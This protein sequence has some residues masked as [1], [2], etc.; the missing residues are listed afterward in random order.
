MAEKLIIIKTVLLTKSQ[1]YG[2]LFTQ[3]TKL[4]DSVMVS[5]VDHGFKPWLHQRKTKIGLVC[6]SRVWQIMGSSPGWV[7]KTIKLG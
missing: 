3:H 4:I 6:L 5:V 1:S 2:I 7:R